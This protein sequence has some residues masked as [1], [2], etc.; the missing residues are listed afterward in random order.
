MNHHI[1]TYLAQSVYDIDYN[2]L[3]ANGK[4]VI[5]FDLDNTLAPYDDATPT[6][7]SEERRV[8]KECRSR[9]SPYH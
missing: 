5:L 6:D 3:Y 4:R 8:G 9:W 7:R 1:P 2:K